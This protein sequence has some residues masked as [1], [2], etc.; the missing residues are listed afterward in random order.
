MRHADQAAAV[1]SENENFA[2]PRNVRSMDVVRETKEKPFLR[3]HWYLAVI[4]AVVILFGIG[5]IF[6]GNASY[7]ARRDD[8]KVSVV[9]QGDFAVNVRA[10]GKLKSKDTLMLAS[11]VSGSVAQILIKPG[12]AVDV[13]TPI[14]TLMNPQLALD[15]AQAQSKLQQT[16]AEGEVSLKSLE[17]QLLDQQIQLLQSKNNYQ[18]ALRELN[19]KVDLSKFGE[20]LVS[21]MDLQQAK[22][23]VETLQQIWQYS[24]KRVGQMRERLD[25]QRRAHNLQ[26]TQLQA[27]VTA[28]QTQIDQLVVRSGMKGTLQSL[29]VSPGQ[30][31]NVGDSVGVVADTTVL[32]AQLQVPEL[33]VQQ[34]R[35]G[36][37]VTID[38]RRSKIEGQVIRIAP[39]VQGG[40]VEVDVALNGTL[41]SEARADLTV[42]GLIK[43]L[44][45]KNVTYM[46][47]PDFAKPHTT[48]NVYRL[49]ADETRANRTPLQFGESSVNQ[50]QVVSG[51]QPGDKIITSETSAFA[52]HDSIIVK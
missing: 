34:V 22:A 11:K 39:S 44:A 23:S 42:D 32:I 14:A 29:A 9:Q 19:V 40:M 26:V 50:I 12:D 5:K 2:S 46:D 33:Q 8:L 38:T 4:A 28:V 13:D 25:A 27:D 37:P 10:T 51:A 36:L 6:L 20:G 52:A 47:R 43:I 24:E 49:N 31:L 17:T 15:L 3:K 7:I 30:K 41:P 48:G 35:N 18:N 21:A 1:E 45:L 16:S